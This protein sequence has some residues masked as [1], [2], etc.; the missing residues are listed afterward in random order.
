[1][2]SERHPDA[3]GSARSLPARN[4]D[5]GRGPRLVG[6]LFL[7]FFDGAAEK[8]VHKILISALAE[9]P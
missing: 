6:T 2:A 9:I 5:G 4:F 1:M 3:V 7:G 8:H